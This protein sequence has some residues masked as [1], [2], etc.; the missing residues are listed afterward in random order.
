MSYFS[1][2]LLPKL[3]DFLKDVFIFIS[4]ICVFACMY[5]YESHVC[6]HRAGQ[7]K[8]LDP[9][10]RVADA[11]ELQCGCLELNLSSLEEQSVT[12]TSN[13]FLQPL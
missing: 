2:C 11:C 5:V 7:K 3:K 8:V 4:C 6:S 12:L 13:L 9:L 1:V 10:S